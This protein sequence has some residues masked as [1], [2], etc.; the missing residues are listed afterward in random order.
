MRVADRAL[1]CG[2]EVK[3]ELWSREIVRAGTARRA[4]TP[5]TAKSKA[6]S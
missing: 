2:F 3:D 4:P 5:T 1:E 6:P